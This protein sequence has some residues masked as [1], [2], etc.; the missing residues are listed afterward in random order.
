MSRWRWCAVVLAGSVW[1]SNVC[2]QQTGAPEKGGVRCV[3]RHYFPVPEGTEAVP[4][5]GGDFET[6][7]KTPP[8]WVLG[9]GQVV[10]A[11]DA[12]QG[13]SYA[14][15]PARKGTI[16]ITPRD[17]ELPGG[18]PYFFSLWL[19]APEDHWTC[20]GFRSDERLRTI[21]DHYPGIPGT[22]NQW[23]R[24]G[25]YVWMPLQARGMHLQIQPH[26]DSPEGQFIAVDDVQLRTATE[27]EMSAAYEADRGALPPYDATPRGGDGRHL[28]LSVAKWQGRA[29]I[30]GKPFLVWAVGSSWTN[31]QGDGYPLVRAIRERFPN[32]PPIVYKKHAGSGTPWDFAQG[33]VRQM[34]IPDQPDLVFTYT[35]GSPEGLDAL[36]TLVR[37]YTTADVI[38]PSL[39]FFERSVLTENEIER[40]VVDWQRVR[41]ICQKHGAEFVENRRELAEYMQKHSLD[42]PALVGDAVHQNHH[43]RIRIWDNVTRHVAKPAEFAYDPSERERRIAV[44]P[45]TQTRTE[46]VALDGPWTAADGAASTAEKDARLTLE[47]TGNRVDLIGRT[48]PGGGTLRVRIDGKPADESPMF[49]TTYIRPEP[50]SYPLKLQ[51]PGA[52]DI[53]PHAVELGEN[54]VPQTW[55]ITMTDDDG[56]YL[57]TGSVTGA[58]GEGRVT[59]PFT[60]RSGQVRI[61]PALW[62]HGRV[63]R[64]ERGEVTEVFFGNREGDRFTFD[65]YRCAT[66]EV[67]FAADSAGSFHLPL[68]QNL[69]N[70]RHTLE[71]VA[72]GDGPVVIEGLYVYQP[73]LVAEGE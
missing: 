28:A 12:P 47:F 54:V 53:A 39:H 21:G 73:P 50:K 43:G 5:P 24:V 2:G 8:G 30:P 49:F 6:D 56:H 45:P 46:Q 18:R 65:V 48:L 58:D 61:D 14:Q 26:K 3:G 19:R 16:F 20:I 23:R 72:Q 10:T 52:G 62:R 13:G 29:G 44:A 25:Y 31:F 38:V 69:T 33:W 34:V 71:L 35:N 60:S 41:E 55:T 67:S 64:R 11:D 27:A 63:E 9:G 32:A 36:L 42:P 51:G 17:L 57:L 40:G 37:R 70:G 59:E 66:G 15:F 7:G 68:V 1:G 22:D 4:M